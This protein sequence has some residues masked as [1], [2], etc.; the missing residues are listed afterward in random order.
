VLIIVPVVATITRYRHAD[1]LT[2]T[3]CF[4]K[5]FTNLKAYMNLLRGHIQCFELSW[6]RKI[7]QVS[8]GIVV[9]ECDF[10]Q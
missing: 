2:S 7:H 9:V 1:T 8:F 10:H 4:K 5:G 6:C 3:G